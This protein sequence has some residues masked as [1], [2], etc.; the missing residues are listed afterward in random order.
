[1]WRYAPVLPVRLETSI[2]SLGEG[3]TP[4]I[5]PPRTGARIGAS[6]L[7]IK[8][9]GLNPTGS[10]KARGLSCAVSMC[11]E[12]GIT[13]AGDS[14]RR[15]RRQR[16]GGLRRGGRDRSPH[17]HAAGCTAGELHRVQGL[18]RG[19]DAGRRADQRLRAHGGG[20]RVRGRAG[21]TSRRSRSPTAS[22]AKRRWATN[23]PSS[24]DGKLPD[25]IF[26]P[27][28]GGVGMIGMW[29]AFAEME[30]LGWIEPERVRK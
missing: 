24:W 2:V 27:T 26:Y 29:K 19:G 14:I 22:R 3:M 9:E 30:A 17:L 10:F 16:A 8:D 1:M 15:K 25:A 4:L 11:V 18:R 28:G 21:S 23:W 6:D 5:K 7:L 20:A 12:L 13:K